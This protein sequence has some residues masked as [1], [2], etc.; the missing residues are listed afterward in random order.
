MLPNPGLDCQPTGPWT[1]LH[2]GFGIVE[3][4]PRR[5]RTG[6]NRG[7][8]ARGVRQARSGRLRLTGKPGTRGRRPV[9]F[10]FDGVLA[11]S[12][13]LHVAALEDF[14]AR[15][16][17]AL[18]DEDLR[19]LMGLDQLQTWRWIEARLGLPIDLAADTREY[20]R[21][22]VA[23]FA[24]DLVEM[25]GARALVA[26]LAD[27]GHPLAV[28]SSS[29]VEVVEAGLAGLELRD[30]FA[31]VVTRDDVMRTKP[32]PEPYLTAAR[33]LGAE[34]GAEP[35][36]CVAIEDS[37][38]GATAARATGM[39]V[40]GLEAGHRTLPDVLLDL[41]VDSLAELVEPVLRLRVFG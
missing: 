35:A 33:R 24:T 9:I 36:D 12:E 41:R 6:D 7:W 1:G 27:A 37:P 11:D 10:D 23:R 31:A 8:L 2:F 14:L 20:A 22:V 40:V 39:F 29:E 28:A 25:P 13:G 21:L 19:P 26:A 15:R 30:R 38:P 34:L 16:G 32:D 3:G 18:P 5:A 4:R 17:L